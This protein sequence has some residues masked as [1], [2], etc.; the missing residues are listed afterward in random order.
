[1]LR[2]ISCQIN[3]FER[4]YSAISGFDVKI[5][6]RKAQQKKKG[7]KRKEK[8]KNFPQCGFS[9]A[10]RFVFEI[11]TFLF[12]LR[13]DFSEENRKKKVIFLPRMTII[14]IFVLIFTAVT[15]F[16]TYEKYMRFVDYLKR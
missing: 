4:Q 1:M 5:F 16:S 12:F 10:I 11:V 14:Y 8:R 15:F 9:P 7:R 6:R 2:R 13:L 3:I